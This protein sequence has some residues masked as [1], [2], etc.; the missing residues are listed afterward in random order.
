MA[1]NPQLKSACAFSESPVD[2]TAKIYQILDYGHDKAPD[3]EFISGHYVNDYSI[4]DTHTFQS[5]QYLK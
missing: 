3:L 5:I 4:G 2:L 1:A